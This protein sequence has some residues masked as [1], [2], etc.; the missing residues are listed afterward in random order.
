[1]RADTDMVVDGFRF[2][3]PSLRAWFRKGIPETEFSDYIPWTPFDRPLNEATFALMTSAGIS[4]KTDPPFDVER[5]KREPVWG[6]PT[7]REIPGTAT[8]ADIDVNHLHINTDYIK[9]D[10]NVM[11]PLARF[12]EFEKEGVI[13]ALAPTSYSFYGFQMNPK[14]LLEDTMPNVAS[15]MKSEGVE[16]VLLTPA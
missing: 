13:G 16:A 4:L 11:L 6:D 2:L 14:V 7:S 12:R 1:M 9:Q 8:E 15:K 10:L 3:P 5:E